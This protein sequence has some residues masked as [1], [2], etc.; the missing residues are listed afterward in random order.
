MKRRVKT[1]TSIDLSA[2]VEIPERER[3][4][5][6]REAAP[7]G[8]RG[9][10]KAFGVGAAA[11]SALLVPDVADAATTSTAV[12]GE[13][14]ALGNMG[15]SPTIALGSSTS[16]V[17]V[18]VVTGTLT[19]NAKV[20]ITGMQAGQ[21]L[22]FVMTQDST[23]GRSLAFT[24][25]SS[26]V[27]VG[28]VPRPSTT[29][30][31]EIFYDGAA[32]WVNQGLWCNTKGQMHLARVEGF[33]FNVWNGNGYYGDINNPEFWI[34]GDGFTMNYEASMHF[35]ANTQGWYAQGITQGAYCTTAYSSGEVLIWDIA[36]P[37][38]VT[39]SVTANST[40]VAGVIPNIENGGFPTSGS[41]GTPCYFMVHGIAEVQCSTAAVAVGDVLVT[42]GTA[43]KAM[44]NNSASV[45]TVLGKAIS[46]KSA[47]STGTVWAMIG[48]V[49]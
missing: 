26:T 40:L 22:K 49:G 20:T 8:R 43:G 6:D 19:A 15:A 44:T 32:P 13:V 41:A 18:S 31:F 9:F 1:R 24:I 23:G 35:C 12:S 45:G 27:T 37:S 34:D 47:G 30:I 7:T 38:N 17:Q 29:T 11:T 28:V 48:G 5:P 39:Q 14:Y 36:H 42:S 3:I 33:T 10:L 46:S 25:G 2:D 21:L 16:D 4:L